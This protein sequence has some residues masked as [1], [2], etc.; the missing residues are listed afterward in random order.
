MTVRGVLCDS[1]AKQ[2]M[3]IQDIQENLQNGRQRVLFRLWTAKLN[4]E[5]LFLSHIPDEVIS[6]GWLPIYAMQGPL[7][8]GSSADRRLRELRTMHL[9]PID[10]KIHRWKERKKITHIYRLG[11]SANEINWYEVFEDWPQYTFCNPKHCFGSERSEV[12]IVTQTQI[13]PNPK[14]IKTDKNGQLCLV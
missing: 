1:V 14:P 12:E 9:V 8:G 11:C 5:I 13:K 10:Y 6:G 2:K 4:N 7:I 3:N